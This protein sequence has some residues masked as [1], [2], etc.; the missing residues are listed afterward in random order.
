MSRPEVLD[1][2]RPAPRP[3]NDLHCC[4]T[5][6]G[7]RHQYIWDTT[8]FYGLDLV[9]NFG[10]LESRNRTPA[11]HQP[12]ERPNRG[13]TQ[14]SASMAST[15]GI[16][17]GSWPRRMS[18]RRAPSKSAREVAS[19]SERPVGARSAIGCPATVCDRMSAPQVPRPGVRQPGG[20]SAALVG[21]PAAR[22]GA[23]IRCPVSWLR[24]RL[25]W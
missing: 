22:A 25:G 6:P 1:I 10:L 24:W 16:T 3:L 15:G 5:G 9:R 18:D 8:S 23:A 11:S 17:R 12:A 21:N 4:R 7:L 19:R 14:V 20:A 13:P 2:Q